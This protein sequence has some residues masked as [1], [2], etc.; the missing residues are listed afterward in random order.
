LYFKFGNESDENR[1]VTTFPISQKKKK[2]RIYDFVK[3]I[4][5]KKEFELD[6]LESANFEVNTLNSGFE[7]SFF[8][9]NQY[10]FVQNSE[11]FS[12]KFNALTFQ[13]FPPINDTTALINA[14]N[15]TVEHIKA[16]GVTVENLHFGNNNKTNFE[17]EYYFI[18]SG[19]FENQEVYSKMIVSSKGLMCGTILYHNIE[20]NILLTDSILKT[21]KIKNNE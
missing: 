8:T 21:V 11:K 17:S 3:N 6:P 4:Y 19:K 7:F 5:Y 18:L 1:V 15:S 20:E 10:V 13:Q 12:E 2:K 16:N 9:M 14:L